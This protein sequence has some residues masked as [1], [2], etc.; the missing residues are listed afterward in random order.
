VRSIGN[1]TLPV[2]EAQTFDYERE[3]ELDRDYFL[4]VEAYR[5]PTPPRLT[6]RTFITTPQGEIC[7]R[8]ETVLRLVPTVLKPA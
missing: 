8:L 4:G 3:L 7:A 6:L 5:T 1:E 2:H